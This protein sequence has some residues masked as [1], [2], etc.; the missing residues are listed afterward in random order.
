MI[1]QT[2]MILNEQGKD[3]DSS[4]VTS[5][6]AKEEQKTQQ[7]SESEILKKL[8]QFQE[9][10]TYENHTTEIILLTGENLTELSK[11]Q[12]VIYKDIKPGTYRAV[13]KSNDGGLLVIYDP[14]E[15]KILKEFELKNIKL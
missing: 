3:T 13:F 12:P 15:N 14:D 7:E 6:N 4:S 2:Q 9:L 1:V 10:K 11:N 8:M 5:N